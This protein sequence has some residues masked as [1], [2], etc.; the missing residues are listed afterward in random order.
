M[1]RAAVTQVWGAP[2]A[3]EVGAPLPDCSRCRGEGSE[4]LRAVWGCDQP[5]DRPVFRITCPVCNGQPVFQRGALCLSCE[6]TGKKD[7]YRCM[8]AVLMGDRV[9]KNQVRALLDA[10]E[11]REKG[12]M[13][14]EGGFLRQS[15]CF[16][17]ACEEISRERGRWQKIH[18]DHISSKRQSAT[19]PGKSSKPTTRKAR[20]PQRRRR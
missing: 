18:N 12:V 8:T 16:V 13:P 20:P 10:Y 11:Y 1:I 7:M 14:V 17:E 19:K 6:G 5:A 2:I 4:E 3:K 9:R 15:A